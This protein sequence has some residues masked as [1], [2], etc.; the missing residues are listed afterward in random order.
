[1]S[2]KQDYFEDEFM[3]EKF[4]N[5]EERDA[6]ASLFCDFK[7]EIYDFEADK[8]VLDDNKEVTNCIH[9]YRY[10]KRAVSDLN[11]GSPVTDY[12]ILDFPDKGLL[13]DGAVIFYLI[14][15]GLLQL[16]NQLDYNDSGLTIALFNK[17]G[18]YQGWLQM[19]L[20]MYLSNKKSFKD[21]VIARQA[22]S[23][24][25]GVG[26]EFGWYNGWYDLWD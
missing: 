11:S 12:T 2:A 18:L 24:F 15:N 8:N 1:M 25:Q 7:T 26:S 21:D 9:M 5:D 23:G 19:F 14:S 17:T 22:N 4:P 13:V 3:I 16:R 10:F 6:V 20:N